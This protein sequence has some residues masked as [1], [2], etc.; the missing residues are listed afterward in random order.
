MTVVGGGLWWPMDPTN[1]IFSSGGATIASGRSWGMVCRAPRAG[2]VTS[3]GF[4]VGGVADTV[5][6]SVR[7][8]DPVT[9]W[10]TNNEETYYRDLPVTAGAAAW[11]DVSPTTTGADGGTA[12]LVA[13]GEPIAIVLRR[14]N[15]VATGTVTV[16]TSFG[17]AAGVSPTYTVASVAEVTWTKSG[18]PQLA[19]AIDGTYCY[20]EQTWFG[21]GPA[22][23]GD[24]LTTAVIG[25]EVGARFALPYTALCAGAVM[26]MRSTLADFE[27]RLYS[28]AGSL[29]A[30]AA[31]TPAQRQGSGSWHPY[32]TWPTD[33]ALSQGVGYRLAVYQ[34]GAGTLSFQ[35]TR[36]SPL[37]Q[38]ATLPCVATTRTGG[39]AWTDDLTRW[40]HF[41]LSLPSVT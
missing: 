30:S 29:L 6:V 8:V 13:A 3:V 35:C 40:P 2:L 16:S 18:R 24:P 4:L 39:G 38:A 1:L 32:I 25:Q 14:L 34:A 36:M 19:L 27:I 23:I 21:Y 33:I 28:G 12:R 9:G 11:R 22:N 7:S 37:L 41:V 15:V 17:I 10:P 20:P 26:G 31:R 5:R